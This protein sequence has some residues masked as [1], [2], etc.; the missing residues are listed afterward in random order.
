MTRAGSLA[1]GGSWTGCD[2]GQGTYTVRL[3]HAGAGR[4]LSV[5]MA[6]T[7]SVDGETTALSS[8]GQVLYSWAPGSSTLTRLV[9]DTGERI[10]Q[11][12]DNGT[13]AV[14]PLTALGGW[15]APSA[16]AKAILRGAVLVSPDGSRVYVL[17]TEAADDVRAPAGS[18]GI[19]VVDA[20]TLRVIDHWAPSADFVSLALNADGS[21]LYAAGLPGVDAAGAPSLAQEASVTVYDTATGA[22]RLIAGR[23]GQGMLSFPG[24]IVP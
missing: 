22:Q 10:D 7:G 13:A 9:L 4:A 15:L 16:A 6:R 12:L 24:P 8:D 5:S 11:R 18:L 23:L 21:L 1:D 19:Y 3:L 17:G 20:S 2:G 14:D